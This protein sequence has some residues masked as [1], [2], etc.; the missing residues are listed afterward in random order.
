MTV[1]ELARSLHRQPDNANSDEGVG[2]EASRVA[3][4]DLVLK[5]QRD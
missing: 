3:P 4:R 5:D 2:D 1:L